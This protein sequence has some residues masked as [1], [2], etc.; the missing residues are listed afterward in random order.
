MSLNRL[1]KRKVGLGILVLQVVVSVVLMTILVKL[2]ALPM[3]VTVGIGVGVFALFVLMVLGQW[4]KGN[5][6]YPGKVISVFLSIL[7]VLG[8]FA[9][10]Q[11][12]DAIQSLSNENIKME[13]VSVVVLSSN[14]AETV[15]EMADQTFGIISNQFRAKTDETIKLINAELDTTIDTAEFEEWNVL[16][17]ALY[18]GEVKVVIMNEGLRSLIH[19]AFPTFDSDTKVLEKYEHETEMGNNNVVDD[20]TEAPF[21]V[22]LS[23]IDTYGSIKKNSRSDVN[24]IATINPKTKQVLLTATPRDYYVPT[25][26][27]NGMEDKLTH[28]GLYGVDCSRETLEM[29]YDIEI[30]YYAKVNFSGFIK[31]IDALGGVTVHSDYRF[32]GEEGHRFVKGDNEVNGEEAL[33]FVRERHSFASG[34]LQRNKNQ[35]YLIKALIEKMASPAIL[36]GFNEVL[37]SVSDC[38]ITNLESSDITSLIQ[39]QISD[40]SSWNVLIN[41]VSGEGGKR[42]TYSNQ[43]AKGYV[44]YVDEEQV[45]K[46]TQLIRD[47]I[48][49]KILTQDDIE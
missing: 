30:N 40:G 41:G 29:L 17:E 7:M 47:V 11:V 25:S 23:G 33:D 24:I 38:V 42:T 39:M 28:A 8:A 14:K 5:F 36:Q 12:E 35:Q 43:K 45:T 48:D 10:Y 22:Y 13:E 46:A 16:I 21:S 1:W 44:M 37:N 15:S 31:V 18:S 19:E 6:H 32:T 20:V 34:D 49:G 3:G 26:V 9:V 4:G 27:S 2:N